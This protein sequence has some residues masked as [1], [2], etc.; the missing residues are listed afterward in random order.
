MKAQGAMREVP[1]SP[2][3]LVP[4]NPTTLMDTLNLNARPRETGKAA[5]KA[6]RRDGLVPCVLYGPHQE[7]V[8]FAV[9]VLDLRPLIQTS[10]THRV[11]LAVDGTTYDCI[12]KTVDYHPVTDVPIHIDFQALTMGEKMTMSV[13]IHLEGNAVGVREGGVLGQPLHEL[14]VRCLPRDIPGHISVDISNMHV[15]DTLHVSDLALGEEI[16]VLTDPERTIVTLSSPRVATED[17]ADLGLAAE[18]AEGEETD[19]SD[20]DEAAE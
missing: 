11:A 18:P 19:E 7:P 5:V 12:L 6:T 1:A 13:P 8:H 20:D 15:G 3:A 16:E 2:A 4:S 17:E 14:E 9:E 10:E